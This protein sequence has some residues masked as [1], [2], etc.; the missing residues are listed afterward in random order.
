MERYID[1]S[2]AVYVPHHP[3][4]EDS[5]GK[6]WS[7]S[8]VYFLED[9]KSIYLLLCDNKR[10]VKTI[11]ELLLECKYQSI[12][13]FSG[14]QWTSRNLLEIINALRN[15]G[16]ISMTGFTPIDYN[17][18]DAS[19]VCLL[20][21]DIE[22][23]KSVYINYF[24]FRE[25]HSF[26][27]NTKLDVSLSNLENNSHPIYAFS[28]LE[29]F[30]DCFI[31]ED[32]DSP[33]YVTQIMTN[34]SEV[35]RFWD[36]YVK[37]GETL[38]LLAKYPLKTWSIHCVPNVRA[39]NIVYFIKTM[40]SDFSIFDFLKNELPSTYIYIPDIIEVLI[41]KF[42]FSLKAILN[43]LI[44]ECTS[45]YDEYRPQSTSAIFISKKEEF[46]FP[47]INNTYFTHLLKL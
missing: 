30:T 16:L 43:R 9:L 4:E 15:F 38:G 31:T 35:M 25:F 21:S 24:R 39:L 2:N 47:K 12:S 28:K 10:N 36:V 46:L 20:S 42:R 11:N 8:N 23:F 19:D 44:D 3:Q 32:L 45:K 13:S 5:D 26:F 34:D 22:V 1:I 29:R 40:P 7:Y 27:L 37:W 18:F 14:K 17:L 6:K 33:R 41:K